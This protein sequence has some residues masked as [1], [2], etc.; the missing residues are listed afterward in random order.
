MSY[1]VI[2]ER[3]GHSD[4]QTTMRVYAHVTEKQREHLAEKFANYVDF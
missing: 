3:L 4:I 1:K 2:Q